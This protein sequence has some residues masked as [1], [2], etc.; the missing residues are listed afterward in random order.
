MGIPSHFLRTKLTV[1]IFISKYLLKE[2]INSQDD[3]NLIIDSNNISEKTMRVSIKQE[4]I[5]DIGSHISVLKGD[6]NFIG[7]AKYS[8]TGV[9]ILKQYVYG[10]CQTEK[11][12]NDYYTIVLREIAKSGLKINYTLNNNSYFWDEIDYLDDY[13]NVKNVFEKIKELII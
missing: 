3:Y 10:L 7:I 13:N 1:K 2:C 8:K 5:I 11:Y 9:K 6:A 4:S 12:I